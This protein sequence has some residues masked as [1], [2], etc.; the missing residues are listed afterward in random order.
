M[1]LL[2]VVTVLYVRSLEL[3]HLTMESLYVLI[4]ISPFAHPPASG[5]YPSTLCLYK[6]NFS[7]DEDFTCA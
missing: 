6:F 1:V 5:N 4:S 3:V 7:L 2:T